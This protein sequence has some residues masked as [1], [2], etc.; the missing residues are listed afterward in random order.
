MC[1][2]CGC[3][4]AEGK[5][6]TISGRDA[7]KMIRRTPQQIKEDMRKNPPCE[8]CGSLT[9][10]EVRSGVE[11]TYEYVC[12]DD[13]CEWTSFPPH[14][15]YEAETFEAPIRQATVNPQ[16]AKN[17]LDDYVAEDV[18]ATINSLEVLRNKL[19]KMEGKDINEMDNKPREIELTLEG[20][21]SMT[22]ENITQIILALKNQYLESAGYDTEESDVV[23]FV[24]DGRQIGFLDAENDPDFD[25]EKAD[26]NKDGKISDWE[27]A[28]GNAVAKSIRETKESEE[29]TMIQVGIGSPSG[30]TKEWT[31]I[32]TV[33]SPYSNEE[34]AE[35]V[36]PSMKINLH[37]YAKEYFWREEGDRPSTIV[38]IT[39]GSPSGQTRG[40]WNI[41]EDLMAYGDEEDIESFTLNLMTMIKNSFAVRYDNNDPIQQVMFSK[42][43]DEMN[44][45]A[46]LDD[47]TFRGENFRAEKRERIGKR[48]ITR[49]NEGKFKKNVSIGRSLKAD[50]RRKAKTV[51]KTSGQGDKGD[52]N[53][54]DMSLKDSAKLGFGVGAGLLGFNLTLLGIATVGGFL[55]NR[56]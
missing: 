55:L 31:K 43:W 30:S 42:N 6:R 13:N 5:V 49:D 14:A 50:R 10:E 28:V 24:G 36:M 45:Q 51:P 7:M 44:R 48:Y 37:A 19:A 53:G 29:G 40:G 56:D 15:D 54:E 9:T 38:N 32:F 47:Y 23:G 33:N 27:R 20:Q 46:E 16:W 17:M 25:E 8:E 21:I 2:T 39:M 34:L 52:Y 4:G 18:L 3:K 1:N 22:P 35:Y 41:D 12:Y 26:R 11:G